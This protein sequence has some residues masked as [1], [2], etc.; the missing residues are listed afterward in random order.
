[1]RL[2]KPVRNRLGGTSQVKA[3]RPTDLAD[4]CT[5]CMQAQNGGGGKKCVSELDLLVALHECNV[6]F[7]FSFLEGG[8][9]G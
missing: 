3:G 4:L 5:I 1:M 2:R 7:S 6:I 9:A 8:G